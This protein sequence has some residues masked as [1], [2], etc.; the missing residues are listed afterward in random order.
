ME[1]ERIAIGVRRHSYNSKTFK[2]GNLSSIDLHAKNRVVGYSVNSGRDHYDLMALGKMERTCRSTQCG[3]FS[4]HGVNMK[5]S[6]LIGFGGEC[7]DEFY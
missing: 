2:T 3:E 6:F 1:H 4:L 5:P 7:F